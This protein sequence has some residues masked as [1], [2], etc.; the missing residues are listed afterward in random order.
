MH[1]MVL[2][3][4]LLILAANTPAVADTLTPVGGGWSRYANERFGT[5]LDVPTDLFEAQ[6]PPANGDGRTFRGEDGAQLEVYGTYANSAIMLP[7]EAYKDN[8]LKEAEADGLAVTYKRGG[9]GWLVYSGLKGPDIVYVKVID[10]CEAAHLFR[11]VYPADRKHFYD[12][13]V[14]RLSRT[15]RCRSS[16]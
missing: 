9:D 12:P 10:S 1:R 11:I 13:I 4:L 7:F 6:E 2:S 15:L 5:S 3:A 14:T 8:L 16:R